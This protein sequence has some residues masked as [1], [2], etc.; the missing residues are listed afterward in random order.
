MRNNRIKIR[1]AITAIALLIA[2]AAKA[3]LNVPPVFGTD[4][5]S[6][7]LDEIARLYLPCLLYTSI[8]GPKVL[9]HIVDTVLQFEGDQHSTVRA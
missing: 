9:E 1:I 4:S 3:Q 6:T 7:R 2:G 8:A 5:L